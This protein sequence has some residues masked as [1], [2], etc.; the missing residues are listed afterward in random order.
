MY[1]YVLCRFIWA[2]SY[3][4]SVSKK[5]KPG[6]D[7]ER[8]FKVNVGY[9]PVID[10]AIK[11][12]FDKYWT[13]CPIIYI[14]QNDYFKLPSKDRQYPD[15]AI[16]SWKGR[17]GVEYSWSECNFSIDELYYNPFFDDFKKGDQDNGIDKNT[18]MMSLKLISFIM[19]FS[20]ETKRAAEMGKYK[21]Y[22][23]EGLKEKVKDYKILVQKEHIDNGRFTEEALKKH[24][25][26]Y[27]IVR[28]ILKRI[29]EQANTE[30]TGFLM[31]GRGDYIMH[32][33]IVDIKTGDMLY[34]DADGLGTFT[35][36]Q[37]FDDGEIQK[38]L[39]S[40]EKLDVK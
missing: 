11:Y 36:N 9:D 38:L 30:N 23:H 34:H 33:T 29:K 21:Y 40:L 2:K 35:Q 13:I 26:K 31:I 19:C 25:P 4:W 39:K 22:Y 28:Q 7:K 27:E 5:N 24:L 17:S 6:G 16:K 12:A 8:Y 3:S 18:Q 15:F 1:I 20:A 37:Q 14:N 32:L 10:E